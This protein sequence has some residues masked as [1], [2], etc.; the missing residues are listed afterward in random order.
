MGGPQGGQVWRP[1]GGVTRDGVGAR[2]VDWI[3]PGAASSVLDDVPE[4]VGTSSCVWEAHGGREDAQR[5]GGPQLGLPAVS[6][7]LVAA[8]P[9]SVGSGNMSEGMGKLVGMWDTS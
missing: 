3:L 6:G 2:E 9:V 1:G 5:V 7:S 4:R 8:W